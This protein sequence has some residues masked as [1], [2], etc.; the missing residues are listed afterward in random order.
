[1][2]IFMWWRHKTGSHVEQRLLRCC[3][4]LLARLAPLHLLW[5]PDWANMMQHVWICQHT[6]IRCTCLWHLSIYLNKE[7]ALEQVM[8]WQ[9]WLATFCDIHMHVINELKRT[10][11]LTPDC[12]LFTSAPMTAVLKLHRF[13]VNHWRGFIQNINVHIAFN[14]VF[15]WWF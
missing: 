11:N 14:I 5:Q 10:G 3:H 9:Q 15:K 4:L 12:I 13:P 7:K 1:M 2:Y 6:G 8:S